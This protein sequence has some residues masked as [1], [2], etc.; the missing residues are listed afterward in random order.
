MNTPTLPQSEIIEETS[1]IWGTSL[2]PAGCAACQRVYLVDSARIG[3]P[4]PLCGRAKLQ[5]QPALLRPEAPELLA[6]FRY[7]PAE[8]RPRLEKFVKD[9]WLRGDDFDTDRLLQRITPIYWPVW[10][11][12][13]D[14]VGEWQAEAGF[15]Y[16]V[17]SSQESFGNGKWSTRELVEQRI[18]WEPR[19]GQ[20]RRHY[21]NVKVPAISEQQR[22]TS[23]IGSCQFDQAGAYQPGQLQNAILRVPDLPP[24]SAWPLAQSRLD[25]AAA[26]E[27]QQASGAQHI[28]NFQLR[29]DYQ[30]L[31]WTQ[32]LLPLYV[33]WYTDDEGNP[34]VLYFNGQ[35]GAIGG[36][37]LASQKKGWKVAGMILII[38]AVFFLAALALAAVGLIFPP[39]MILGGVLGVLAMLIACGA[40]I[41]AV[42]P[43][44]WNRGQGETS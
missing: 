9:V 35:S 7:Q 30:T 21:D 8:L 34:R 23:T 3:Q 18:R 11:L 43:W 40:I 13:G 39:S 41:P 15:D 2:H 32:L 20:I 28:R 5:A 42:W 12:D 22:L 29:A 37:R 1:A 24:A 6:P 10:L 16:Q 25:E 4:C 14:V 19:A 36:T 17:K 31:H 38:A 26:G 44:Q 27:C 33:S